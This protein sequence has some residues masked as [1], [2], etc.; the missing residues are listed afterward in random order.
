MF[1]DGLSFLLI[2]HARLSTYCYWCI[3]CMIVSCSYCCT[4]LFTLLHFGECM[5][6][7][8]EVPLL[9]FPRTCYFD[10]PGAVRMGT[11]FHILVWN[12][13]A[14]LCGTGNLLCLYS[15]RSSDG[16]SS[17]AYTRI[18]CKVLFGV[19]CLFRE[20]IPLPT[21]PLHTWAQQ[22]WDNKQSKST[23]FL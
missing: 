19:F 5:P 3:F 21:I 8:Q 4:V 15:H 13:A 12:V 22:H 2:H 7:L 6:S 10:D 1:F 18:C 11:C 9:E 20:R 17:I 23:C 16:E 14:L